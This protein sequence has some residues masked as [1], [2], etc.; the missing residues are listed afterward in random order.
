MSLTERNTTAAKGEADA[1]P[2]SAVES[3]RIV[4][5]MDRTG[6]MTVEAPDGETYTVVG[7]LDERIS[8]RLRGRAPGATARMELSPAPSGTG[9]V[10]AR[11][12]PGSLP[13]F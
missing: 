9:Y 3:Y 7:S 2:V 10:V 4:S 1:S 13:G 11:V 6:R 12:K 8:K 5:P